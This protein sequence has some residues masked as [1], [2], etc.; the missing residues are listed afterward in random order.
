[1]IIDAKTFE[2]ANKDNIPL[3]EVEF[4]GENNPAFAEMFANNLQHIITD[5]ATGRR[6][7]AVKVILEEV[8]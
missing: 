7:R 8:G 2:E 5:S 6:Y 4:I 3:M 1:M